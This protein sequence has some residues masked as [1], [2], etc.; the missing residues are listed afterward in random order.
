RIHKANLI[1]NGIVPIEFELEEDYN[2]INLK[3]SQLENDISSDN[4]WS[5]IT[6]KNINGIEYYFL[7]YNILNK[8]DTNNIEI[9]DLDYW[10]KYLRIATLNGLNPIYWSTGLILLGT[11]I[12]MPI[13]YIPTKVIKTSYG[14]IVMGISICGIS[15]SPL[16]LYVNLSNKPEPIIKIPSITNIKQTIVEMKKDITNNDETGISKIESMIE[17]ME[18]LL[19]NM[20]LSVLMPNSMSFGSSVKKPLLINN[21]QTNIDNTIN[22]DYINSIIDNIKIPY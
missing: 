13:V 5:N 10:K 4:N 18:D 2:N 16:I 1:N 9:S 12:L 3:I 8:D 19:Y 14:C 11:P 22:I 6:I 15:I 17:N 20:P 7:N 21:I